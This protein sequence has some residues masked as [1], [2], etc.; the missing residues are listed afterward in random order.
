MRE[1]S[2]TSNLI[3][4]FKNIDAGADVKWEYR[5]IVFSALMQCICD[6]LSQWVGSRFKSIFSKQHTYVFPLTTKEFFIT[7][8]KLPLCC[9]T[10]TTWTHSGAYSELLREN[11]PSGYYALKTL[12]LQFSPNT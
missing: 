9:Y 7:G 3:A 2:G 5:E 11:F 8:T 1:G 12:G 10:I 4:F 6:V